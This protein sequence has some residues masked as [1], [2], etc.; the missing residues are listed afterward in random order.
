M[1]ADNDNLKDQL[2]T[3]L[4]TLLYTEG[5]PPDWDDEVFRRVLEQMENYKRHRTGRR[6]GRA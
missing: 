5:Y 1:K 6:G 4:T 2:A 3:D